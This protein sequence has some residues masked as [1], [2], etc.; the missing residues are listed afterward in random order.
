M[1]AC[2]EIHAWPGV[3]RW[4]SRSQCVLRRDRP[5]PCSCCLVTTRQSSVPSHDTLTLLFPALAIRHAACAAH[6]PHAAAADHCQCELSDHWTAGAW[7]GAK[8]TL[9]SFA[10]PGDLLLHLHHHRRFCGRLLPWG[11]VLMPPS[12][13]YA[14]WSVLHRVSPGVP[15]MLYKLGRNMRGRRSPPIEKIH[16]MCPALSLATHRRCRRSSCGSWRNFRRRICPTPS[17]LWRPCT[18]SSPSR[19]STRWA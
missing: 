3:T 18:I 17:G 8:A 5:V 7:A 12:S 6:H 13:R 4:V 11:C 1:S 19:S 15:S 16:F 9:V 10:M 14:T 2:W